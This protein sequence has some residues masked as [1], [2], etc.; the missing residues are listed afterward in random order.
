MENLGRTGWEWKCKKEDGL[1]M[2][3]RLQCAPDSFLHNVFME[4]TGK[5]PLG[6]R[7]ED[8]MCVCTMAYR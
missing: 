2:P 8:S 6:W 5:S 7:G 4:I 1:K 3:G